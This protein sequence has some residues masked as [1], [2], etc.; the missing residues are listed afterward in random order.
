MR[1]FS[2]RSLF[3]LPSGCVVTLLCATRLL[4]VAFLGILVLLVIT[5]LVQANL[6]LVERMRPEPPNRGAKSRPG[7][8]A[9]RRTAT[10]PGTICLKARSRITCIAFSSDGRLLASASHD[11][12]I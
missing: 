7:G 9:A 3:C 5:T 10:C 12:C 2:A 11:Y 8:P 4:Q 6:P 1:L